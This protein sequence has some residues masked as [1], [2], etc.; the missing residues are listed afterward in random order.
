M[1]HVYS[2][3]YNIPS[4]GLRFFTVYGPWGR[5][6]MAPIIFAD[7]IMNK[8]PINIFNKGNMSRDFT[9]IDDVVESII[10]L[11]KKPAKPNKLFDNNN[12]DCASS[13]APFQ[14][15]NIGNSNPINLMSFIESLEKEIG[16]KAIKRYKEMEPGDV[17]NTFADTKLIEKITGFKPKTS[18][19]YGV[20]EFISWYRKF[21]KV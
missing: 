1:A 11:I 17:E 19:S 3:L 6:D 9:F 7:A 18:V 8:K 14:I 16:I 12:P 20:K 4:T 13:C 10:R 15:L 5:P 2:H 21:Y